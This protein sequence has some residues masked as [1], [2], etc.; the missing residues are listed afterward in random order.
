[1][2]EYIRSRSDKIPLS[3]LNTDHTI[4]Y[5]EIQPLL[6]SHAHYSLAFGQGSQVTYD[7][8]GVEQQ[9][10][11]QFIQSK[12]LILAEHIRFEYSRETYNIDVFD[13]V[14]L[15]VQQVSRT[16]MKYVTNE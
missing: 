2:C 10:I 4:E 7:F 13:K 5:N 11:E 16:S 8:E 15:K 12:P 3:E 14:Y 1:M 6:L 9:F